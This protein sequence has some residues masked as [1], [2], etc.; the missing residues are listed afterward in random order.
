MRWIE[1]PATQLRREEALSAMVSDLAAMGNDLDS[2][3]EVASGTRT[4]LYVWMNSEAPPGAEWLPRMAI[5][6]LHG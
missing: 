6:V 3:L 2:V 4:T 5:G 1:L